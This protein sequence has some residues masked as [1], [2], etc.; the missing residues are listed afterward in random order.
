MCRTCAV[1]VKDGH[2]RIKVEWPCLT[3]RLLAL[4]SAGR[5]GYRDQWRP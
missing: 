1:E 5:P 2:D 4:P 3:V